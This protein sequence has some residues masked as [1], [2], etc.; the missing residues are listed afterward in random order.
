[1]KAPRGFEWHIWG[2]PIA[3]GIASLAGLLCAL[4]GD[5]AWDVASWLMLGGLALVCAGYGLGVFKRRPLAR[6]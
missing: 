5:G 3:I 2:W 6:R 1:M 4:V